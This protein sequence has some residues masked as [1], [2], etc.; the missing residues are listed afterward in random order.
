MRIDYLLNTAI[1]LIVLGMFAIFLSGEFDTDTNKKHVYQIEQL[2][3]TNAHLIKINTE[4]I[5]INQVLSHRLEQ[6]LKS[7]QKIIKE[8]EEV[9]NHGKKEENKNNPTP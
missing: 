6:A 4:L 8:Q 3:Q 5:S 2:K 7:I 9:F 1:I